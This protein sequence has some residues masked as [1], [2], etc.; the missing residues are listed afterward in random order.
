[1]YHSNRSFVHSLLKRFADIESTYPTADSVHEKIEELI[2]SLRDTNEK[3]KLWRKLLH[4]DF[5]EYNFTSSSSE[6]DNLP[7][8]LVSVNIKAAFKS[9]M[10]AREQEK[11]GVYRSIVL[12]GFGI[13]FLGVVLFYASAIPLFYFPHSQAAYSVHVPIPLP[14]I[15]LLCPLVALCISV[16]AHACLPISGSSIL[17]LKI[18]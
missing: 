16:N 12:L 11:R 13:M 5:E 2:D 3:K 15:F 18:W 8:A 17:F 9:F 4:R 14:R 7:D 1:M 10:K 6:L